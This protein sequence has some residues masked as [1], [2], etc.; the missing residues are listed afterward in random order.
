[1]LSVV[2]MYLDHLSFY[3]VG[4]SLVVNV[5]L[6]LTSLMLTCSILRFLSLL[7]LCPC[8]CIACVFIWLSLVCL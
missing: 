6:S 1:M 7:L 4:M 3:I 2:N 5:M 8:A